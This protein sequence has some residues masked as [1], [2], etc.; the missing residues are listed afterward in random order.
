MLA[1]NSE[2]LLNSLPD[3]GLCV[4]RA[5]DHRLLYAN[6]KAQRFSSALR[7]AKTA[8]C[9]WIAQNVRWT[10]GFRPGRCGAFRLR[11]G[12]GI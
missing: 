6:Q 3:V 12:T 8:A 10:A 7:P 4:V 9:A 5:A 2:T 1:R 11:P